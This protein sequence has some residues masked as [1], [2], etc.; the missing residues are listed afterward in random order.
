MAWNNTQPP[1]YY[2]EK[3]VKT[4]ERAP[5]WGR[6]RRADDGGG[7]EG[8]TRVIIM[9][10]MTNAFNNQRQSKESEEECDEQKELERMEATPPEEPTGMSVAQARDY[11]VSKTNDSM[12]RKVQNL[13]RDSEEAPNAGAKIGRSVE[14]NLE[15]L[16]ELKNNDA[17]KPMDEG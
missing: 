10:D 11:R 8:P 17:T 4:N 15:R 2:Y 3:W 1:Y 9:Y 7:D 6:R 13:F 5:K 16:Q 12:K 14:G